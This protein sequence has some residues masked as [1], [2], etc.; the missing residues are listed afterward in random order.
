MP[1]VS[2]IILTKNRLVFLKQ[3]LSSIQRQTYKDFEVV[4]VDDGS[5]D[6]SGDFLKSIQSGG[7]MVGDFKLISHQVSQGITLSRQEALSLARGKYVSILDDDDQWVDNYKLRK[8]VGFLD[9]H[10]EYV[11]VGGGIK[12]MGKTPFN[13]YRPKTDTEIRRTML[14]RNNFFTSTVMFRRDSAVRVGGFIKDEIDL[15]E[16]YDL[17]LRLG[18]VGKMQNFSEVFAQY[19]QPAYNKSK[20]KQFLTKQLKLVKAN[21]KAYPLGLLAQWVLYFRLKI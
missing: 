3:A 17:W 5:N 19:A 11:L 12:I 20:F 9:E 18:K 13:K 15:A 1:K 14:F 8:Q 7:D 2:I 4:V 10:P 16:D 6:G 21:N